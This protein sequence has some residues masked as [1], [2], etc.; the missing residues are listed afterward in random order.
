MGNEISA[1]GNEYNIGVVIGKPEVE[2]D[3]IYNLW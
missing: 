1:T 3:R 2:R